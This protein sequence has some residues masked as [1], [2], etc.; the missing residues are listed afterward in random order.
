[1]KKPGYLKDAVAK[2]NGFYT[3]KGEK[4]KGVRL[5]QAFIDEWNGVTKKASKKKAEKVVEEVVAVEEVA[6]EIVKEEVPAAPTE[7]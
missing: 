3:V 5:D 2:A 1:M 4:L 6:E 7:E